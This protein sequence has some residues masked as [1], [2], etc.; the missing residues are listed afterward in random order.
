M[1]VNDALMN[2]NLKYFIELIG[3]NPHLLKLP[4]YAM[5]VDIDIIPLNIIQYIITHK[6]NSDDIIEIS[7][8]KDMDAF[9]KFIY[10]VHDMKARQLLLACLLINDA[11]LIYINYVCK[12]NV[13]L[14]PLQSPNQTYD[15]LS[16][17]KKDWLDVRNKRDSSLLEGL[18]ILIFV[19]F[20]LFMLIYSR[21]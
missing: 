21:Y 18:V 11:P 9:C 5:F 1:A 13:D 12:T 8:L 6:Q 19:L 3:G 16:K 4:L 20:T 7:K 2:Y 10:T 15:V 17:E 14:L